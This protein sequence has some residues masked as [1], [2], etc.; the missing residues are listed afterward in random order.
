M[1]FLKNVFSIL[2]SLIP[3]KLEKKSYFITFKNI[4]SCEIKLIKKLE[5]IQLSRKYWE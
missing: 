3:I 2:L 1:L 4:S 5:K